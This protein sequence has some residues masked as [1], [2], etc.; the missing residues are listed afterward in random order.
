MGIVL[1]ATIVELV[2]GTALLFWLLY[3]YITS[4]FSYWRNR[5]ITYEEPSFPF[6]TDKNLML[7][8]QQ[9]GRFYQS[10]YM[11]FKDEKVVGMFAIRSPYLLIRD[12]ELLKQIMTKDF[13]HF[14]DRGLI[15]AKVLKPVFRHLLH[16]Q[17]ESWKLMR[18]KLTP[19]FTSGKMKMMFHLMEACSN[20][21]IKAIEP[22]A[23]LNGKIAVKDFMARF[24]TDV[25]ASC[26]FGLDSNSIKNPDS[27]FRQHG[28]NIVENISLWR[29]I[30]MRI[31]MTFPWLIKLKIIGRFSLPSSDF[32]FKLT[33]DTI[34]YREKNGV[35]RNDFVDLLIK[36]KNNKSLLDE[37]RSGNTMDHKD[38]E[39]GEATG[40]TLEELTAQAIVFFLAGFETS[41]SAMSFCLY[42][43]SLNTDVQTK[44]RKEIDEVLTKYNGKLSYEALQEMMYMEAVI[45]ETLRR[46]SSLS[47][48]NRQCTEDYK[49]QE[50]NLVIPKG[51]KI[52]IPVYAIHHDPAY[53][54][55]PYKFDPERFTDEKIKTKNNYT[56]MPFGE[57]PRMCIGNRFAMLQMKLCLSNV[58]HKFELAVTEETPIPLTISKKQF[59][60]I[61]E[62][63]I[64]LKI[65]K[66]SD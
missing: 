45:N 61:S 52:V 41:S 18:H 15:D 22:I 39:N 55:D 42:E 23:K 33:G 37:E 28:R 12:P 63:P 64:V 8:R 14:V 54:P 10:I 34:E 3:T 47:V 56:F 25:I 30:K 50:L 29:L 48:L 46:Y 24:T 1:D 2:L 9:I 16:M 53:Y 43:I 58:L 51:M 11:K 38:A 32:F 7:L 40:I 31:A 62:S 26:A 35:I 19:A 13:N 49:L 57:G 66:R 5:S 4:N 65:S 20:E 27:E 36:I 21:L 60:T 6:G 59:I 17:G 44:M